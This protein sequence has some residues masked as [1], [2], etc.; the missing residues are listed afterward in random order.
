MVKVD[1]PHF[2][3]QPGLRHI[4]FALYGCGRNCQS[5]RRFFNCKASK[6]SH[7]DNLHLLNI[8]TGK[9]VEGVVESDEVKRLFLRQVEIRVQFYFVLGA[10]FC[11]ALA[12]CVVHQ[13]LPHQPGRDRHKMSPVL[14]GKRLAC[15]KTQIS[16]VHQFGTLQRMIRP[17]RTETASRR[18]A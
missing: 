18:K 1:P 16:F 11:R 10:A 2:P 6:K 14:S 9:T 3:R 7:F 5:Y 13:D 15:G 17:L 12:A 8:P 4:P